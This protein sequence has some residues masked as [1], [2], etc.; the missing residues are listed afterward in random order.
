[1]AIVIEKRK[2]ERGVRQEMK[3]K[4]GPSNAFYK[5]ELQQETDTNLT[6]NETLD[7]IES[8][9]NQNFKKSATRS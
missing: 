7:A 8:N 5:Q 6:K 3:Y 4:Q 2:N 9:P 1:M